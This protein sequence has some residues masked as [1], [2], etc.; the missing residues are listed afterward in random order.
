M[1]KIFLYYLEG[2]K[3]P[4]DINVRYQHVAKTL[5][6][7]EDTTEEHRGLLAIPQLESKQPMHER[8]RQQ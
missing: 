1:S 6:S 2:Q 7:D 5:N 8:N 4:E 3:D